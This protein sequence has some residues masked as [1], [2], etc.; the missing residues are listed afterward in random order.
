ML[1]TIPDAANVDLDLTI[2]DASGYCN[3]QRAVDALSVIY[4]N[5]KKMLFSEWATLRVNMVRKLCARNKM[6]PH[7]FSFMIE[8]EEYTHPTICRAYMMHLTKDYAMDV[9]MTTN[10]GHV[11]LGDYIKSNELAKGID[12]MEM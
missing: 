5:T 6:N 12:N 2:D 8:G 1:I 4:P 11:A 10:Y 7:K 3:I 9:I